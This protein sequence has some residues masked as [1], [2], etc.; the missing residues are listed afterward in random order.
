MNNQNYLWNYRE[1]D[2]AM[3]DYCSNGTRKNLAFARIHHMYVS[4]TQTRNRKHYHAN[5]LQIILRYGIPFLPKPQFQFLRKSDLS[6]LVRIHSLVVAVFGIR[7]FQNFHTKAKKYQPFNWNSWCYSQWNEEIN[8]KSKLNV[9]VKKSRRL[10]DD[11]VNWSWR[12]EMKKSNECQR[13]VYQY[14]RQQRH[15]W[16][17]KSRPF[18]R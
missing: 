17:Q 4:Y 6:F 8:S 18:T 1:N 7:G 12:R 2:D 16:Q 14:Y 13:S 10:N 15:K 11:A 3:L 9:R 5:I